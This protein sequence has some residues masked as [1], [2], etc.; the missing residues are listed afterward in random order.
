MYC[1][2]LYIGEIVFTLVHAELFNIKGREILINRILSSLNMNILT[3]RNLRDCKQSP[4]A[5]VFNW[6]IFIE[7]HH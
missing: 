5:C 3:I 7:V 6:N 1:V 4:V 2:C